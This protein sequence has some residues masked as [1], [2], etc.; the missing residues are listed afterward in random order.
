[1]SVCISD[2][3]LYSETASAVL[4]GVIKKGFYRFCCVLILWRGVMFCL[5]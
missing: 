2:D 5:C 3:K 4:N 1:M